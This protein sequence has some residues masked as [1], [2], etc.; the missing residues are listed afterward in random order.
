MENKSQEE[1][2]ERANKDKD[3]RGGMKEE[4]KNGDE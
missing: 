1:E 2:N 4:K 3:G